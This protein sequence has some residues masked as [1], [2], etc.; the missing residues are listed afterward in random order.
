M[1]AIRLAAL[2]LD[3]YKPDDKGSL[4]NF[5]IKK[6]WLKQWLKDGNITAD[7]YCEELKRMREELH[8]AFREVV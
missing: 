6:A 3:M 4:A 2:T 5:A 8:P 7:E 1:D